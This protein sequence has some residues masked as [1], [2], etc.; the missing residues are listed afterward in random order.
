MKNMTKMTKKDSNLKNEPAQYKGFTHFHQ[1]Y[2]APTPRKICELLLSNFLY[3]SSTT[4]KN[5]TNIL[6]QI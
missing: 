2:P 4:D 6:S 1:K 3:F 5:L